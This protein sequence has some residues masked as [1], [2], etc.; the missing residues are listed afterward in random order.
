MKANENNT[1]SIEDAVKH[2]IFVFIPFAW[3]LT[4]FGFH[5]T[6]PWIDTVAW[7]Q[8]PPLSWVVLH[9]WLANIGWQTSS[10]PT[11]VLAIHNSGATI[12]FLMHTI[13]PAAIALL[14]AVWAGYHESR[15][16]VALIH[17]RGTR[18]FSGRQAII[19]GRR[20]ATAELVGG[21]LG[22]HIHPSIPMSHSRERLGVLILGSPGSG[23]T[24]IMWS[25]YLHMIE[26][27]GSKIFVLDNKGDF[28]GHISASCSLILAPWDERSEA[29]DIGATIVNGLDAEL[30]ASSTVPVSKGENSVFS[31]AARLMLTGVIVCLQKKH[32]M[33]W[34]W[35]DLAQAIAAPA[36]EIVVAF[37]R[38]FPIGLKIFRENSRT[39]DSVVFDLITQLSFIRH[40]AAAWPDSIGKFNINDWLADDSSCK[41]VFILQANKA[42]ASISD[43]LCCA[44]L[45][46]LSRKILSPQFSDSASRRLY[47]LLDEIAQIPYVEQLKNLVALGRS[48]GVS[49]WLGVQDAGLLVDMYGKH[50]MESLV[51]MLRTKLVLQTGA[52]HGAEFAAKLLGSREVEQ[53]GLTKN[54]DGSESVPGVRPRQMQQLVLPDEVSNIKLA[55]FKSGI[56]G[57]LSVDGWGST[58]QLHWQVKKIAMKRRSLV[59][60]KWVVD[61]SGEKPVDYED[62]FIERNVVV[63]NKVLHG[64]KITKVRIHR[65]VK[66]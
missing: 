5:I 22:V 16:H 65:K 57:W 52:G 43:P 11:E 18:I 50:E 48:K 63:D 28:T 46:I 7:Q 17:L 19:R 27:A 6:L 4:I 62:T 3:F 64:Q 35:V 8:W 1:F 15:S 36:D 58:L 14:V 25:A 37:T 31:K 12:S 60:A 20:A 45:N 61:G 53:C 38:D 2:G 41:K 30:F 33:R 51:S 40:L 54:R 39:S 9:F 34:G 32:G 21:T 13:I 55:S 23:K 66:S 29:W 24:Q 42:Y 44:V 47:F 59:L 10:W 49:V 26:F 56:D